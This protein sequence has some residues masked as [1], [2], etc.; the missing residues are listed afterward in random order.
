MFTIIDLAGQH[1]WQHANSHLIHCI[2]TLCI[3]ILLSSVS[4]YRPDNGE[5]R[6]VVQCT[7]DNWSFFK[8]SMIYEAEVKST[9][10]AAFMR[11]MMES[12]ITSYTQLMDFFVNCLLSL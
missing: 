6:R 8:V 1:S 9:L 11:K 2:Y 10:T 12:V 4:R 5:K 7:S 3:I